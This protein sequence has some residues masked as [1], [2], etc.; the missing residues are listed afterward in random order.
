[1]GS[2][3]ESAESLVQWTPTKGFLKVDDGGR[4]ICWPL[5][6]KRV[7]CARNTSANR[8]RA[9]AAGRKMHKKKRKLR[10]MKRKRKKPVSHA[11]R[12]KARAAKKRAWVRKVKKAFKKARKKA[13]VIRKRKTKTWWHGIHKQVKKKVSK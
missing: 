5:A 8:A 1:M 2:A 11:A 7:K 3:L 4:W 9:K 13:K 6:H 12:K 10:R